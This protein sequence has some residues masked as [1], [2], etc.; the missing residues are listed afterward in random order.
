MRCPEAKEDAARNK[1]KGKKGWRGHLLNVAVGVVCA[2]LTIKLVEDD[3]SVP[4]GA[5]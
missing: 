2:L 1:K 3:G 5:N 4:P